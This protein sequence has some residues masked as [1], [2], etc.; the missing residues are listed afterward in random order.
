[1]D[2]R[3][4]ELR[5]RLS[6]KQSE[7]AQVKLAIKELRA[8]RQTE[9]LSQVAKAAARKGVSVEEFLQAVI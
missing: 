7:V 9:L 2:V 8:Q 6:K 5:E 3:I 1:M 4:E